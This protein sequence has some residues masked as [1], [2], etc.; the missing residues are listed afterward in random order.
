MSDFLQWHHETLA[1]RTVE[2]LK[3]HD[4]DAVYFSKKEQAVDHILGFIKPGAK[5]GFGGSI[6]IQTLGLADKAKEKGA[7]ILNHNAP[8]L[9]PEEK[10]D[11]RRQQ[12]VC[13]VFLSSSN[14]VTLDGCIVNVDAY[15]NRINALTFGPRKIIIVIGINKIRKDAEEALERVQHYAAPLNNKRI[16]TNNPCTVSGTCSECTSKGRICRVYSVLRR[17]P[18]LSDTTVVIVGEGLGF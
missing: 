10:N 4:F 11:I 15:G 6:T 14:A 3:A 9:S 7:V 18:T 8:G 5:V 1:L 12:L 16:G 17:K 13:D 2:A